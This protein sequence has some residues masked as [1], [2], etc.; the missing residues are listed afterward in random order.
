M[1]LIAAVI[2]SLVAVSWFFSASVLGL[3]AQRAEGP[4]GPQTWL[5]ESMLD[6]GTVK[7]MIIAALFV[8]LVAALRCSAA[9]IAFLAAVIGFWLL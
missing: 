8:F 5:F 1:D 7:S 9:V 6:W 2:G 3:R 4:G